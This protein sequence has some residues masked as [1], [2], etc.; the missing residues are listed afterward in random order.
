MHFGFVVGPVLRCFGVV[1]CRPTPVPIN[2]PISRAFDRVKLARH[3]KYARAV[4][5]RTRRHLTPFLA[6][7]FAQVRG[8]CTAR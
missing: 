6:C 8:P 5:S 7:C 4:P 1:P 3:P 2:F